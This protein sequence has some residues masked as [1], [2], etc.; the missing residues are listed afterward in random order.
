[1]A[2]R[3]LI[4][5]IEAERLYKAYG[6]WRRVT[7]HLRFTCRTNFTF[8]AVASAVYRERNMR[9][10]WK[11]I[12]GFEGS[13]EVS[14]LGRVRSLD[15]VVMGQRHGNIVGLKLKG[16]LLKP[17]HHQ[18]RGYPRVV[19]RKDNT[20]YTYEIHVLVLNSFIG[21]C[22]NGQVSRHLNDVSND[23]K[24]TN[25]C[26]GTHEENSADA[27]RN[28]RVPLG[29][30]VHNAKLNNKA[31]RFIRKNVGV[32]ATKDMAK[33]FGVSRPTITRVIQGKIWQHVR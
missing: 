14:N 24:L 7:V 15:R 25:L 9:E 16:K 18:I 5:V 19:L 31:I 33:K 30:S 20:S 1:M 10:I 17:G 11:S 4:P 22:P 2:V 32:H 29:T 23:N 3:R 28:G 13:Y 21:P 8:D 12:V 6:N 26:W 27:K